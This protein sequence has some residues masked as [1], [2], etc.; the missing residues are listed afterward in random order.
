[1]PRRTVQEVTVQD[2]QK[3]RNPN[4]HYVY[5]IKVSWSDGSTEIIYRRYSKFFDLQHT[6]GQTEN[7]S[8]VYIIQHCPPEELVLVAKLSLP[9]PYDTGNYIV[10]EES[11]NVPMKLIEDSDECDDRTDDHRNV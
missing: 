7:K 3:R 10:R 2:V 11:E 9:H 8:T 1:M 6:E 5:I 4:K